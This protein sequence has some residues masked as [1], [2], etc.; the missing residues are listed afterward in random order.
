MR[1]DEKTGKELRQV[2]EEG[3][4]QEGLGGKQENRNSPCRIGKSKANEAGEKE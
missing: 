1:R 2:R 3:T 4:F